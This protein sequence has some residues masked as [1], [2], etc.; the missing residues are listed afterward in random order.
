M[1]RLEELRE[2]Y[3]MTFVGNPNLELDEQPW[4]FCD[5]EDMRHEWRSTYD[6]DVRTETYP[7]GVLRW[8]PRAGFQQEQSLY[9]FN[10][11]GGGQ[12]TDDEDF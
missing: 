4:R 8:A 9:P 11:L 6:S 12:D 10:G 2:K 3:P 5:W 1:T 7:H